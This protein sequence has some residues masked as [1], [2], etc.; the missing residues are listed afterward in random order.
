MS[1]CFAMSGGENDTE[2]ILLRFLFSFECDYNFIKLDVNELNTI[3]SANKFSERY[4]LFNKK[5]NE[6]MSK[7]LNP[8][9]LVVTNG[10]ID[11]KDMYKELNEKNYKDDTLMGGFYFLHYLYSIRNKITPV[12]KV[13]FRG[14]LACAILARHNGD[15]TEFQV[16]LYKALAVSNIVIDNKGAQWMSTEVTFATLFYTYI[17]Q[18]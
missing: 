17:Y 16:N 2:C 15:N 10:K 12:T 18:I 3:F 7:Y 6:I 13:D 9:P 14:Y 1:K 4:K 11:I 8:K 5:W